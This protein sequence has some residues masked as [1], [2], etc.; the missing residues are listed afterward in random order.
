MRQIFLDIDGCLISSNKGKYYYECLDLLSRLVKLGN[1]GKI[2][3]ISFSTGRDRNYV[4]CIANVLGNPK[5]WSV[6]ES[7]IAFFQTGTK[8]MILNPSLDPET[9]KKFEEM[10]RQIREILDLKFPSLFLYPGTN[11]NLAIEVVPG[12]GKIDDYYQSFLTEQKKIFGKD[13]ESFYIVCSDIAIDISPKGINKG[14]GL[15]ALAQLQ[16]INL[17]SSIGIGDSSGDLTFLSL[18]GEIGCPKNASPGCKEL[19]KSKGG[20]VSEYDYAAGVVDILLRFLKNEEGVE[21]TAKKWGEQ[22]KDAAEVVESVFFS[23]LSIKS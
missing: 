16:N 1:E 2:P 15:Q 14:S 7:G 5:S 19:V 6:I 12:Q 23:Y 13:I 10:T 18:L 11:V 9:K 22:H 3:L 8:E 21:E 17:S 4:E 20:I